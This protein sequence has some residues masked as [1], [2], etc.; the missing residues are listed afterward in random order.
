MK[1]VM[2]CAPI[3]AIVR[4]NKT[5]QRYSNSARSGNFKNWLQYIVVWMVVSRQII[6]SL[7]FARALARVQVLMQSS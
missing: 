5:L 2:N 4:M 1:Q 6:L 7:V 3:I